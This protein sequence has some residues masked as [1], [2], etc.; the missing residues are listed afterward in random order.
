VRASDFEF[1]HRF[2]FIGG[3]F[4]LGFSISF[5]DPRNVVALLL[6]ASG[7]TPG[8]PEFGR[9]LHVGFAI[10]ALLSLACAA[11]RTWA[12]AYLTTDVVHDTSVH[13]DRLVADG[14]YR[15]VRNPL[16][17][18]LFLLTI[19]FAL[20][21]N[22]YGAIVMLCG[23]AWIVLRLIGREEGDLLASQGEAYAAYCAA[24]PRLLPSIS[25]R[26]PSAGGVPRYAQ[27]FR[28]E[29]FMGSFALGLVAFAITMNWRWIG[30]GVGLGYV[31]S[32]F[33]PA[34]IAKRRARPK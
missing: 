30:V 19:A 14:P 15:H 7:V 8:S 26:V 9:A 23:I 1:R 34:R 24:V 5:L 2:A 29:A 33:G 18:A 27:A 6:E 17:F 10:G 28:G 12:A 13:S 4:F 20:L 32:L 25:P 3:V 11:L 31:L 16:Y 22:P 21:A